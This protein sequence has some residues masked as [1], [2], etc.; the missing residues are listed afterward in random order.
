[1]RKIAVI[2]DTHAN[3]PALK[4]ALNAIHAEGCDLIYHVGDAIA[5]EPYRQNVL[6]SSIIASLWMLQLR[7]VFSYPE[8][9]P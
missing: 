2:T 9:Q 3:L 8:S 4:T 7:Q 5:L 1:M 6:T